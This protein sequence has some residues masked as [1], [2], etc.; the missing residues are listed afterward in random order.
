MVVGTVDQV[1]AVESLDLKKMKM[2]SRERALPGLK[3]VHS[4]LAWQAVEWPQAELVSSAVRRA[5]VT[6]GCSDV[7]VAVDAV[8]AV[9]G[10]EATGL[11]CQALV[12]VAGLELKQ[13]VKLCFFPKDW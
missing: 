12:V 13:R 1:A 7:V 2:L 6:G 9:T 5:A 4:R 11:V 10:T 8:A 3:L